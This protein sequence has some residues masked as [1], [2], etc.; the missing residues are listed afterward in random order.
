MIDD[1]KLLKYK[2]ADGDEYHLIEVLGSTDDPNPVPK[3]GYINPSNDTVYMA[4]APEDME[5]SN[6]IRVPIFYR[7]NSGSVMF[8]DA[9]TNYIQEQ[10]H[11]SNIQ[12]SSFKKI[13]ESI[14][15]RPIYTE[16]EEITISGSGRIFTPTISDGD[17]FL[18]KIVKTLLQWKKI[19]LRILQKDLPTKYTL[20][21]MKAALVKGTKMTTGNFVPWMNLLHI[22]FKMELFDEQTGRVIGEAIPGGFLYDSR[23]DSIRLVDTKKPGTCLPE[24]L[25]N[26]EEED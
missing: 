2:L 8:R 14:D 18:K 25:N 4:I 23:T 12:T 17:D 13:S 20:T 10:F 22:S 16:D 19:D 3:R 21:N 26:E 5:F 1:Q 11:K 15:D 9:E 6:S 24:E 7:D